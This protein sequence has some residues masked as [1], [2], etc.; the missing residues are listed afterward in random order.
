MR[1]VDKRRHCKGGWIRLDEVLTYVKEDKVQ[2]VRW[3][4]SNISISI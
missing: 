3:T 4:R 1:G 2:Y